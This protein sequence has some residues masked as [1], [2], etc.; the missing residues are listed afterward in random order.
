MGTT[1]YFSVKLDM[2]AESELR[3]HYYGV[4]RDIQVFVTT[5]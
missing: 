1:F 3:S 5:R 4:L 2:A